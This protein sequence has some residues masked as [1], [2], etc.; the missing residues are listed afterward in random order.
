MQKVMRLQHFSSILMLK[1]ITLLQ[2]MNTNMLK[3]F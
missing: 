3:A 1:A 2:I